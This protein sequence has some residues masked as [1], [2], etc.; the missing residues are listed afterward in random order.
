MGLFAVHGP[1]V[2]RSSFAASPLPG[3]HLR[4][5]ALSPSTL[6]ARR[7]VVGAVAVL[8]LTGCSEGLSFRQDDRLKITAPLD[9]EL[10]SEPLLVEWKMS[11]RP[12][13]VKGFLVFVDRAPQP[14]GKTIEH[15]K[16]EN[17]SN[18]YRASGTSIEIAALE[19][20]TTGPNSRRD[21]HRILI[22]PVDAGG[23]RIGENSVHIEVDV[24]REEL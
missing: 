6:A 11:P 7:L 10:V 3:A 4:S 15:F 16:P 5:F 20:A 21:Q 22:V 19:R 24:F 23:R 13:S 18:V 14:P 12:D 17:R 1:P 2:S 9:G 8:C